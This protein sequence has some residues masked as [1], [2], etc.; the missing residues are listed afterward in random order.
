MGYS[1][2]GLYFWGYGYWY[3]V[4]DTLACW[5]AGLDCG[6]QP[7]NADGSVY[8]PY[9]SDPDQ[10][11]TADY[12]VNV[13][14]N[15]PENGFGTS[16]C[17]IDLTQDGG[18]ITRIVASCAIG[19]PYASTL[20]LVRPNSVE[21]THSQ[22]GPSLAETR[23]IH[24]Y[25]I[26]VVNTQGLSVGVAQD[27]LLPVTFTQPNGNKY[28]V[29]QLFTGTHW[30]AVEDDYGFDSMLMVQVTRPYPMTVVSLAGFIETNDRA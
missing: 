15:P 25:G 21:M 14:N 13:S 10:L 6:D 29:S 17:S 23:R 7:I 20:Q 3:G 4:V 18:A 30:D 16:A 27:T 24:Q 9:Q 26:R 19:I 5:I 22:Y 2:P 28:Q 12:L 8:V 1:A 11:L